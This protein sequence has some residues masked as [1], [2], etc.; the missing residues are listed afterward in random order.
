MNKDTR[1][2]MLTAIVASA[3]L[4]FGAA[5]LAAADNNPEVKDIGA[6][7]VRYNGPNVDAVLSYR[8][9]NANLGSDWMMLD[10]AVTGNTAD[11]VE[12]SRNNVELVTPNGEVVNLPTQREFE[13]SWGGIQAANAR[14]NVASEPVD[15][16]IGRR[17]TRLGFLTP[18]GNGI[19]YL[20][21]WVN[22]RIVSVGR[23]YFELP[24]GVQQGHYELR[25]K[26]PESTVTIPFT[27]GMQ[28]S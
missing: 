25:I 10:L 21:S 17:R 8:F 5:Q 14:A 12:V 15:M 18:P 4:L 24:T 20:S 19:A 27:L 3:G 11:A 26:L 28:S 16:W 23:L 9:A 7:L 6:T 22:D 2:T 13:Q 1:F